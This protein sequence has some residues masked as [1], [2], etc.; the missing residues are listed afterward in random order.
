MTKSKILVVEDDADLRRGLARRLQASG[1]D[2]ILAADGLAA[3]STAR[4]EHP[5]LVVLDIGLPAGDGISVLR[6]YSDIAGLCGTP[7]V[8]LTGRDPR[9]AEPAARRY[10]IAGFLTKPADNAK[11]LEVIERA[12]R[13]EPD[14]DA[15]EPVKSS[16]W[17]G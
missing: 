2:V 17:L 15:P 11:L 1:Y 9:V 3:V 13:R 8:V 6:R 16:V 7:V 12:L 14:P 4:V 5:D 10:N